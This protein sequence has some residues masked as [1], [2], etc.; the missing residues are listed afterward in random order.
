MA[1]IVKEVF[2]ERVVPLVVARASRSMLHPL[3]WGAI[4]LIVLGLLTQ[5]GLEFYRHGVPV[6][7]SSWQK[8]P[9]RGRPLEELARRDRCL[10][11]TSPSPRDS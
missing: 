2:V 1:A 5:I 4:E 10:L 3:E 11:Y 7:F 8:L 6:A 9:A